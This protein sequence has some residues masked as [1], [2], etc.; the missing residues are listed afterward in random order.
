MKFSVQSPICTADNKV[1][2]A[3]VV[4]IAAGYCEFINHIV[5]K[6]KIA[7]DLNPDMKKFAA[8][9]VQTVCAD[10]TDLS[11][12]NENFCDVVFVSNF[13]EH[14]KKEDIVKTLKETRRILKE[15]GKIL[16]LQPNVRFCYK[17]Y[18]NFFDHVTPLDDRSLAE[19]LEINGFQVIENRP[20]FLPYTTKSRLPKAIILIRLYLRIRILQHIFGKQAFIIAQKIADGNSNIGRGK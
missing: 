15:K 10:S 18:W 16:I 11:A 7:V 2:K 13:F 4:E 14:L 12:L 9:D 17:D 19:V 1:G 3:V 8:Y 20:K 6:K 5:A